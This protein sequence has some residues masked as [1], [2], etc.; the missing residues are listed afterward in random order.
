MPPLAN[1]ST[2]CP[3]NL[4]ILHVTFFSFF[5]PPPPLPDGGFHL[6]RISG[7]SQGWERLSEAPFFSVINARPIL[8]PSPEEGFWLAELPP[9]CASLPL[10]LCR[11]FPRSPLGSPPRNDAFSSSQEVS[12]HFW[13]PPQREPD[14]GS[15]NDSGSCRSSGLLFSQAQGMSEIKSA[16]VFFPLPGL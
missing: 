2:F 9:C 13:S 11:C 5:L 12:E 1:T 3:V 4:L 10:R 7:T 8:G 15:F 6:L 16:S 14:Q